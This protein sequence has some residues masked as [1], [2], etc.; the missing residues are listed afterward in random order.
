M[1]SRP[2]AGSL[3]VLFVGDVVGRPG[4]RALELLLPGLRAEWDPS[5]VVVNG[6]NA[7]GGLGLTASVAD[8]L[9]ALG[10]DVLTSGNHVWDKKD[11]AGL[12]EGERRLLRPAN[13]PPGVPGRGSGVFRTEDGV[14]I[15]VLNLQGR[16]FLP[17]TDC[18]FRVGAAEVARLR[19]EARVVIVDFHAEATSEK[20]ALAWHL[21]GAATAVLG[22]HT[23]VQTADERIVEG[24]TAAITDAGMTGPCDSVIGMRR[25]LSL[26]RFL[27]QVPQ[28]FEPAGGPLMLNGVVV[29]ADARTGAA[30][31]VHR[32][33]AFVDG[34][35]D[36]EEGAQGAE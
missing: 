32:V 8:R 28:R 27:T 25:E 15:G 5:L 34:D 1:P 20:V 9:F 7:A 30:T 10:A 11:A 36:D 35:V 31:A 29:E 24:F 3:R 6:E 21:A 16:V 13:Y 12:L 18:P 14:P 4:R 33:R 19:E 17:E 22:T 23:H 2:A 26:G